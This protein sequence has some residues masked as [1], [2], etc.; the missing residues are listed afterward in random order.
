MRISGIFADGRLGN[1]LF[2][3]AYI[4]SI[5][6]KVG[7]F[8][9]IDQISYNFLPV[10]YFDLPSY[11]AKLNAV[12]TKFYH[13]CRPLFKNVFE[14]TPAAGSAGYFTHYKGYYQNESYF[15]KSINLVRKEFT[16]KES[17]VKKFNSTY[18]SLF[19]KQTIAVHIRRT[20]ILTLGIHNGKEAVDTSLPLDYYYRCFK[21][22]PN[23]DSYTVIFASDDM[24][25]AR[26]KFGHMAN[27]YI[28]DKDEITDFLMLA[29]ADI[30]ITAN[31][32]FSWW[33][34][35]L[36][37]KAYKVIFTPKNWG[38]VNVIKPPLSENEK[39]NIL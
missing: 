36:N 7:G 27:A 31:S 8:Y 30:V 34:A 13:S 10:K 12:L 2:Q 35:Y 19:Q 1:N 20:D 3:Y 17:L 25:W 38:I 15:E 9:F 18:S 39:W 37:N 16:V 5:S 21:A 28:Q 23:F 4:L 33:A 24:E 32:S 11:N 6:K 26:E 14:F 29:N 22:I